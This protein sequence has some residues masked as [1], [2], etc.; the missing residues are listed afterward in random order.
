M[1][2]KQ[3]LNCN[4]YGHIYRNCKL[5]L[6]S[7]GVLLFSVSR[8]EGVKYLLIQRRNTFGYVEFIRANIKPTE[9]AL[10]S[11]LLGEVTVSEKRALLTQPFDLL[12]RRLWLNSPTSERYAEEFTR[13]KQNF[14]RLIK[15]RAFRNACHV[16]PVLWDLPEWGLPK[17]KRNKNET[18][19]ACAFREMYEETGVSRDEYDLLETD[20]VE[21]V[22]QGTDNKQYRHVYYPCI[23]KNPIR[24]VYIDQ[25]N[26]LQQREVGDI[27]W[28]GLSEAV[29]AIRPYNTEKIRIIESCYSLVD[30]RRDARDYDDDDDD[31]DEDGSGACTDTC[32]GSDGPEQG[33]H[34]KVCNS[35][36]SAGSAME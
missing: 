11:Q 36:A 35:A 24:P 26:L 25:S 19:C 8:D 1:Q 32:S 28:M 29:K 6:T 33:E 22:F 5:P 10:I 7:Y 13:S 15:S 21:E 16:T 12:W 2:N 9:H 23:L 3:C 27:K 14:E 20:P 31:D 17:G 4:E 18:D 30:P 34:D